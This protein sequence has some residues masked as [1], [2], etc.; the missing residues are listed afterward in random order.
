MTV[1]S[2]RWLR[3]FLARSKC[4][5]PVCECVGFFFVCVCAMYIFVYT[6]VCY[7]HIYVYMYIC[8]RVLF[9]NISVLPWALCMYI[10]TYV[11]IM[12]MY[13]Y[14]YISSQSPW[15]RTSRAPSTHTCIRL[16]HK[17]SHLCITTAH[18]QLH[19]YT[20]TYACSTN[21]VICVSNTAHPQLHLYTH[22]YACST[23]MQKMLDNLALEHTCS[24]LSPNASAT[25]CGSHIQF[26]ISKFV[27][28]WS[29]SSIRFLK[30]I[31][32][33]QPSRQP[34]FTSRLLSP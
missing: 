21:I 17:H 34:G 9:Y 32:A 24:F 30:C 6:C 20:H 15:S 22:T 1:R 7:V 11:Y 14:I 29:I 33:V 28:A 10:C 31:R 23:N 2:S 12:Y 3:L 19:L 18:P 25:A 16:L 4:S 13:I 27:H 26:S 8:V 5:A